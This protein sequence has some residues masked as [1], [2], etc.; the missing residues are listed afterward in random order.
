LEKEEEI[1]LHTAHKHGGDAIPTLKRSGETL[2]LWDG[3]AIPILFFLIII[4]LADGWVLVGLRLWIMV[5][6]FFFGEG[7]GKSTAET[8]ASLVSSPFPA[9]I[10][11]CLYE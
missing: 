11:P 2:N 3:K 5:F 10:T 4:L 9:P 7:N 6:P 8:L 1:S